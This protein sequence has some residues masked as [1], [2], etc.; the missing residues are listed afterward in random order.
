MASQTTLGALV[1]RAYSYH[2]CQSP[3]CICCRC[4]GWWGLAPP[5]HGL[6]DALEGVLVLTEAVLVCGGGHLG[7]TPARVCM[8]G[9]V[10]PRDQWGRA[11][12]AGRV[13]G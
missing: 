3:G 1:G 13:Y 11:H 4:A 5:L 7:M 9:G 6:G 8:L 10:S 2:G 12:G